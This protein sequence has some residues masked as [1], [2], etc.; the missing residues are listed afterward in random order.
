MKKFFTSL[1]KTNCTLL[2]LFIFIA[3]SCKEKCSDVSAVNSPFKDSLE[4]VE[5]GKAFFFDKRFSS[6]STISCASCHIPK[7]A[8]ADTV[9]ISPGVAGR[10]GFRNAPSILNLQNAPTFMFDAHIPTL[11]MQAIAP[12]QDSNEMGMKM[13]DLIRRLNKDED[14]VDLAQKLFN[15]E[16]DAWVI[17]RSLATFQKTLVS[18]SSK[19]DQYNK[20]NTN[21]LSVDEI[22]GWKLFSE[23]LYC[24]KCHVP[25]NF[26]NY[27]P[28]CN[29]VDSLY[30]N[31]Q[32]RYRVTGDSSDIGKFKTPSLRNIMLTAPYMHDGRFEDIDQVLQHYM[33]GG[34]KSMNQHE[35]IQEFSLNQKE[36]SQIKQFLTSLTDTS[37]R[38]KY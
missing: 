7:F 18:N 29:G 1:V 5:L 26:T 15:R 28:V 32:G 17:T 11:E 35:V 38:S 12:I 30:T 24:T 13:G 8:F 33:K 36:L 6:D 22:A 3:L 20:G 14:Y 23:R 21:A 4:I 10:L 37:Y 16:L 25:P 19:F 34:L 27:S 9:S 2:V 31:D